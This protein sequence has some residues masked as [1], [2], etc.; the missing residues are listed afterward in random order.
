MSD[1]WPLIPL[2][3]VLHLH[4]DTVE[5]EPT[6]EY[7][8]AGIYSFGRGLLRRSPVKGSETTFKKMNRLHSGDFV[9]SQLKAWEGALAEIP[10][11]FNN[12]FVS[13][14][15]PTFRA[16][17][18]RLDIRYLEWFCKQKAV[19]QVLKNL[20]RGMGA[21]RETV[22]PEAFLSLKFPLPPLDEQRRIVRWLEEITTRI[23]E[24][25][26]ISSAVRE[27]T[28]ALIASS[29]REMFSSLAK[30]EIHPIEAF[31]EVR[32]GIQKTSARLP[33]ANPRRYI[34]VAHVQMD[35]ILLS[36]PRY[37]EVSDEELERWRLKSG[38]VLTIEG[39]GSADQVGRTAVFRGEI[40][41]CV[42]QNH[43]IR[44][45]VDRSRI[46]PVFL[47]AYLNSPL[48][49]AEM[50]ARGRTTSGLYNLSVG[51]IKSI[52]IPVPP[53]EIQET[54]V[55][56]LEN[57]RSKGMAV[58]AKQGAIQQDCVNLRAKILSE[59]VGDPSKV[60][61]AVATVTHPGAS[62]A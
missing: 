8:I 58:I 37:F 43:V 28:E 31:A 36:D 40:K 54:L 45:R 49:R 23:R 60:V 27:Q 2:G 50:L 21:R 15:F 56:H 9:I 10:A 5:V 7:P 35:H 59:S 26:D 52:P 57:V 44:I 48:G 13:P 16:I 39:N 6:D 14:N 20:A 33:D 18:S 4:L 25:E 29:S 38:D 41:D 11:D 34:T 30:G 22:S 32:G 55:R 62:Q 51:R 61:M 1:P 47:N 3:E 17:D 46:L 42:H 24:T 19:W 12:W 53:L